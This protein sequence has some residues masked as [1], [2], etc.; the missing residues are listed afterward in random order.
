M[1]SSA[2]PATLTPSTT[3]PPP[4]PHLGTVEE[5]YAGSGTYYFAFGGAPKRDLSGIEDPM[6]R[7][8]SEPCY[9]SL[10]PVA[11]QKTAHYRTKALP[12]RFDSSMKLSDFQA[13]VMEHLKDHGLDT[14][15][16]LPDPRNST[17]VLSVVNYHAR[18]TGDMEKSLKACDDFKLLYDSWDKKNDHDAKRFLLGSLSETTK[19]KFKPFHSDEDTFA[20]T[21]LRLVQH[22]VT[23]TSKTYDGKKEE[24]RRL[25]PQHFSGQNIE[26]MATRY[27]ELA[28]EISNAGHYTHGLTLN[29]VD[30]FLQASRD[31]A[32]TFHY[33]V[34]GLR[35]KVRS[36]EQETIFMNQDE[37]IEKFAKAHLS[38]N[39]ICISAIKSYQ[40]LRTDNK[41]EPAMLPKDKQTPS[42]DFGANL[43]KAEVLNLIHSS[44]SKHSQKGN[45][46][47]AK[48][49]CFNCGSTSHF[50]K[51]CPNPK[52]SSH[53]FNK[54]KRHSKMDQWKLVAPGTSEPQTKEVN[55]KKYYW[56]AKC[57]NWSTTHGTSGHT[58]K[59]PQFK[60]KKKL[61]EGHTNLTT[62]EPS[63]WIVQAEEVK[64]PM[65][66][67]PILFIYAIFI[68]IFGFFV[69]GIDLDIISN[70]YAYCTHLIFTWTPLCIAP[71]LWFSLGYATCLI[72][73]VKQAFNPVIDAR[74]MSRI[75]QR[76]AWKPS[77]QKYKVKSAKAHNLHPAYPLRLRNDN[78]FN[79]RSHTPTVRA[80]RSLDFAKNAINQ[81][82]A[83]TK[84]HCRPS[85]PQTP[86]RKYK[87]LLYKPI[88]D[89]FCKDF[90]DHIN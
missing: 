36:L 47:S 65:S 71:M 64:S 86:P 15:S 25:K 62:W 22:L 83:P 21:W 74:P 89:K 72:S 73:S 84:R 24:I 53:E 9:R 3:G 58:G 27:I 88:C 31:S 37:Q 59:P 80:R 69:L 56:C 61:N 79:H 57:E 52:R 11:G 10:D 46:K 4:A 2:P 81:A 14:L 23:T 18:F 39:D 44:E 55:G 60:N 45:A 63:A 33:Q 70:A 50:S 85:G 29:M 6:A 8:L 77:T 34:N 32:G 40:E 12:K 38:Y 26:S 7:L 75:E 76:K 5:T 51:D 43:T 82:S 67:I 49:E 48:R 17:D 90:K 28:D 1:A 54:A 68:A 13:K 78:V 35:E 16:Y 41:W 66:L 42:K 30:G 87:K 19:D 20:G